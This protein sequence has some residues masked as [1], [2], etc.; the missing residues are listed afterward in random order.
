MSNSVFCQLWLTCADTKQADKIANTLLVKHLIACARLM[1]VS[2]NFRWQSKIEH[3]KE[4]LLLM[5]SRLDLFE[6]IEREVAKLHSYSVF[7]LE[8]T[9]VTKVS[10][11]AKTW[12][13]KE[14][15]N[16]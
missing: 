1:P 8:A 16:G 15:R 9:A 11:E 6:E 5:E 12:L 4:V 10:E 14:L 3:E 13:N 7:V 2:S